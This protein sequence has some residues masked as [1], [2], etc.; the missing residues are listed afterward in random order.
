[1][2]DRFHDRCFALGIDEIFVLKVLHAFIS[3][4]AVGVPALFAVLHG[5]AKRGGE[6]IILR[7]AECLRSSE[8]GPG[9]GLLPKRRNACSGALSKQTKQIR[10]R[11]IRWS[12]HS[13][14]PRQTN[15]SIVEDAALWQVSQPS[16]LVFVLMNSRLR[17][18]LSFVA[19]AGPYQGVRRNARHFGAMILSQSN[20]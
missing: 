16:V 1:M 3:V 20:N 2:A 8:D 12:E 18:F 15:S 4:N 9:S 13:A 17:K 5:S 7:T 14:I 11:Q 19:D 10:W 6:W